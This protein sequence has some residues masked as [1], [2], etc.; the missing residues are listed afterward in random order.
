MFG[1][2]DVA[3]PCALPCFMHTKK[4]SLHPTIQWKTT[5]KKIYLYATYLKKTPNSFSQSSLVNFIFSS[6]WAF[7]ESAAHVGRPTVRGI[8]G[9]WPPFPLEKKQESEQKTKC[10]FF[11]QS[12]SS[13]KK[14]NHNCDLP[15]AL[16]ALTCFFG[17][18]NFCYSVAQII[19]RWC[20][21]R[22]LSGHSASTW[23][24]VKILPNIGMFHHHLNAHIKH[25][26]KSLFSPCLLCQKCI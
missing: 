8:T 12:F 7:S 10:F 4:A 23:K 16:T 11:G 14:N 6:C 1:W 9:N 5:L 24:F 22:G 25:I 19:T 26:K 17:T 18:W 13:A 21:T 20:Q 2:L 15:T 3:L